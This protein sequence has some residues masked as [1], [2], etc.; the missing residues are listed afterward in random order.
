VV[1]LNGS[2]TLVRTYDPFGQVLDQRGSGSLSWGFFG[3]LLDAASG[4][5]YIGNGQ[6]YDPATGRFL[7]ASGPGAN[8]Y[9]PRGTGDPLGA[10]LAPVALISLWIRRKGR[11]HIAPTER[12]LVIA[13][14]LL[15]ASAT[16]VACGPGPTPGF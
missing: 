9:L 7:T 12:W 4:L 13:V 11:K 2:I 14:V 1:A 15:S 10:L 16:I 5:V 6:Y 8:P 3:G